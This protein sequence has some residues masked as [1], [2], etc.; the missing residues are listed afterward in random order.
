MAA[1]RTFGLD[2][3]KLETSYGLPYEPVNL[4]AGSTYKI[5]TAA[6]ALEK[7]LGINYVLT[8]PPS[9]YASPIYV[10]GGGRPIPVQNA[11]NYADQMSLEEALATSPNTAFVKL[12]EFTGV[13][14]VVDMAVRLGMKSLA[15][16]PFVDP[17]TRRRTD[18]SIA[19]SP[20]PSG[21]PRSRSASARRACWS[22]RTSAP[23]SPAQAVVPAQPD[24]VGHRPER[25]A[26]AGQGGGRATQ[27]VD[28]GLANTM[29]IGLSQDA[30]GGT[31]AGAARQVGWNRPMAGKTG[32]TQQ[33]KSAAFVGVVPQMAGAVITFDD[34]NSP[35]PLCDGAGSPFPCGTGNIF[36]GKTP[37]QTWF[38]A[39]KPLLD[40]QPVLPLPPTD[41]RYLD[42]A[43]VA[44]I[45]DVV[46]KPQNEAR[47]ILQRAKAGPPR[48]KWPT[49][50]PNAARS[51][52]RTRRARRCPARRCCSR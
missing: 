22:W 14:D 29:M 38:G 51:S 15:T 43:P 12:E 28:P 36:G 50:T 52:A 9:G 35:R 6:T 37:A 5:F 13:P 32:T 45:P 39:M 24:R 25:Q 27:A 46:G 41:P 16:T 33:H 19:R 18:R 10:D 4:G 31:A 3:S 47:A 8:V 17:G 42:G 34:T 26:G 2:G 23:R 20:R 44:Q 21:R 48:C 11:G 7:G 1:N 30:I 49:T 40:G